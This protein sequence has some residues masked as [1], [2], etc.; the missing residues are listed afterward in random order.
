MTLS[1]KSGNTFCVLPWI[2]NFQNLN[3]NQYFCCRS[4]IPIDEVNS[5]QTK[6][7]R[8][9]IWNGKQVPHC[10]TCYN[11]EKQGL[12]SPR[13]TE[14]II[15]L[16]DADVYKHFNSSNFSPDHVPFF[17]DL[18]KDNTCNLACISCNA[19]DSSLWAKELGIK[20]KRVNDIP[21]IESIYS[22]KKIYMAGGEPLI[23][24]EYLDIIKRLSEVNPSIEL[25]INTNL[26]SFPTDL[27]SQLGKIDK[28]SLIVS[29][30]SYDKVND[31]H[32]YPSKFDR[33][34]K[35]LS[36]V[37]DIPNIHIMINTVVDAISVFGFKD[38]YK[39]DQYADQ[40]NLSILQ[41]P[42]ELHIKNIPDRLKSNAQEQIE[43]LKN[44]KFYHNDI[45]FKQSLDVIVKELYNT[46]SSDSLQNFINVIDKRRNINHYEYLGVNLLEN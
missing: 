16:K 34:I 38:M 14:S 3:G 28:C 29:I 18:R 19:K 45:K 2:S 44:S 37:K 40:W 20:N 41:E 7:I 10:Q 26:T 17:V 35:N 15:W 12:I 4:K 39:L 13:Q 36:I 23:I 6:L 1:L 22:A 31:Y 42:K 27:I 8:N 5:D 25:V 11:S 9:N 43:G 21:N 32:R 46:G 30:D 24:K 33:L